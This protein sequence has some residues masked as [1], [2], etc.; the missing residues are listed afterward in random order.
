IEDRRVIHLLLTDKGRE[1]AARI[2]EIAPEVLNHRLRD[3]S[4][5]EFGEF[6]RLLRKFTDSD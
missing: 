3:F 6:L 1:V 5:E 2:P 4:T